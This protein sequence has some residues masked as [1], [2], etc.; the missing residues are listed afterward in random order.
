[1]AGIVKS[2]KRGKDGASRLRSD[3]HAFKRRQ[4]RDAAAHVFARQGYTGASTADIARRLGMRQS[5][6]YYYFRSKDAALE[7]IC[8]LAVEGYVQRLQAIV[9]T[10]A[11]IR[12]KIRDAVESHLSVLFDTPDLYVTFLT[13]RQ[14]LPGPARRRVGRITRAYEKLLERMIAEAQAAGTLRRDLDPALAVS[15]LLALCNNPALWRRE[16]F[17]LRLS[18]LAADLSSGFIDGVTA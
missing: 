8:T 13:C 15:S 6:L 2:R 1:M 7:E 4:I 3:G 14:H 12:A 5:N 17:G 11:D 18:E 16:G 10:D 9:D